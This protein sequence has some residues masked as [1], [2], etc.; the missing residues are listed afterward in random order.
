V[1]IGIGIATTPYAINRRNPIALVL[2]SYMSKRKG[3]TRDQ[4]A[5][6][7][8][9]ETGLGSPSMQSPLIGVAIVA[10]FLT[11]L[12]NAVSDRINI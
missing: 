6:L 4:V 5:D 7:F 9:D 12:A 1:K 3:Q 10:A 8:R 2:S 11:A